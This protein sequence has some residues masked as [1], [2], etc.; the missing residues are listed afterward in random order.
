VTLLLWNAAAFESLPL[1][2][3]K[4]VVPFSISRFSRHAALD[5]LTV[6]RRFGFLHC[7]IPL[8]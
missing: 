3:D 7:G 5:S 6:V 2:I 1:F 8:A 4:P